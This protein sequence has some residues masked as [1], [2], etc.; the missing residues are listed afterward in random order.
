MKSLTSIIGWLL[1]VAVLAVPSFLF[2]NWWT[3]NKQQASAEISHGEVASNLFSSQEKAPPAALNVSSTAPAAAMQ[4]ALVPVA[5][6]QAQ[7]APAQP[8]AKRPLPAETASGAD[9][10]GHAAPVVRP[11]AAIAAVS[12]STQAKKT[13]S[14]YDP[15]GDRDPTL[16]P[17]DY[18]RLKEAE[19]QREEEERERL[20]A[21]R[22]RPKEAT[23]DSRVHLQGIVGNAV[24]IN[25]DMYYAGQTAAGAKI[26]KVGPNYI[27]GE[28]KGRKFR[29]V[30]Q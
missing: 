26:L 21:E 27:L 23:C 16:S 25:G 2:Y 15:K 24:I 30:M 3:K 29:K 7:D 1:L 10:P 13:A 12:V 14:Y 28:C 20:I 17:D 9:S 6:V 18:R 22:N 5:P 19:L 4:P 8:A 11:T